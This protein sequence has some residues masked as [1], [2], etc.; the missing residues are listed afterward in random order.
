M[1]SHETNSMSEQSPDSQAKND[2]ECESRK[3]A[4]LA[5]PSYKSVGAWLRFVVPGAVGFGLDLWTKAY[6]FPNGVTPALAG[7]VGRFARD[8]KVL[9]PN[10]LVMQTTCNQGAVFGILQGKVKFFMLFS[11]LAL[12]MIIWVFATSRRKQRWLQLALGLIVAGALGNWYDRAALGAVRDFLRFTVWW[13]PFIFNVADVLLCIGVPL[14]M[15]CWMFP[16]EGAGKKVVKA[17]K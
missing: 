17:G 14:L 8:Q 7:G 5:D 4:P 11:L 3:D 12:G 6:M 2:L 1:G 9:I 13:Y 15:L 10:V 16:K